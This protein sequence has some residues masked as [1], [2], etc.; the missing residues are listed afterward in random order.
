MNQVLP[1][2]MLVLANDSLLWT[3]PKRVV[4]LG[5]KEFLIGESPVAVGT[6]E[7]DPELPV[8]VFASLLLSPSFPGFEPG[9]AGA[10]P[11]GVLGGGV[12]VGLFLLAVF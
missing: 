6:K 4:V 8:E 11:E 3:L 9:N 10:G 1:S 5:F 2:A 12:G 7:F